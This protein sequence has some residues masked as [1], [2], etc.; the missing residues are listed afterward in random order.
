MRILLQLIWL[1]C[2]AFY[3]FDK[4]LILHVGDLLVLSILE[5]LDPLLELTSIE[6]FVCNALVQEAKTG[7]SLVTTCTKRD[8]ERVAA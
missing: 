8:E 1:E 7:V 2:A 5:I 3:I 4:L 6:L